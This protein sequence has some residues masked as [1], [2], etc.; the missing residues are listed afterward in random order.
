MK[1]KIAYTVDLDKI[2]EETG[3]LLE[4]GFPILEKFESNLKQCKIECDNNNILKSI[5]LLE[6]LNNFII[7]YSFV[8]A[9]AHAI[10]SQYLS[11]KSTDEVNNDAEE[12]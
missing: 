7:E 6:E 1:V 5:S 12:G 3:V 8:V 10:L 9:D 2:P 4:R 11:A